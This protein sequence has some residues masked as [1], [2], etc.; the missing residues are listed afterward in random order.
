MTAH[1]LLT[2]DEAADYLKLPVRQ[3]QQWRYLG[4]GP[5]YTHIGRSVRYRR[6]W[7]DQWIDANTVEPQGAA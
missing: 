2:P 3:L 7:L 6:S 1:D 5:R 4:R